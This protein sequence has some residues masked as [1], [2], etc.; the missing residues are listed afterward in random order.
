MNFFTFADISPLV[1]LITNPTDESLPPRSV[2]AFG[3]FDG[4]HRGHQILIRHLNQLAKERASESLLITFWPHP[5]LFLQ[6]AP[7]DFQLLSSL[8][9]KLRLLENA[10]TQNLMVI[11]FTKQFAS[12]TADQF[13]QNI[14][15]HQIKPQLILAG[16]DVRFGADASGNRA[17]LSAAGQHHGWELH[18][19]NSQMLGN[20]RISSSRI[21]KSLLAGDLDSAN[22]LL[23][24][25]YQIEGKVGPGKQIGRS[26]GFPTANIDCC[27]E[28]KLVPA[29][30]VYAVQTT[31]GDQTLPGML[32]IGVR[33]T[34][35]GQ[36]S[37]TIEVHLFDV[38][39]DL[40]GETLRISFI[41]RLRDEMKFSGLEALRQQ[42]EQDRLNAIRA[43]AFR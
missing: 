9:E 29:D 11:P 40:Y 39:Q 20:E 19:L 30:G 41:K 35:P 32:N 5:R 23:G 7:A 25:P 8:E 14:L 3:I 33:P 16:E 4:V 22:Y 31:L 17:L 10:G 37:R 12:L 6:K 15:V 36:S 13:I 38:D 1:R 26:I 28:H 24:Y 42:L 43:L 18:L 2:M 34:L 27:L 21:R